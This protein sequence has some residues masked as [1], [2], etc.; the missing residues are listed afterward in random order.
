MNLKHII[1][2]IVGMILSSIFS[3]ARCAES[4]SQSVNAILPQELS[5]SKIIVEEIEYERDEF[6]FNVRIKTN[7]EQSSNLNIIGLSPMK[8]RIHTNIA[9][10]ITV[11][12]S[13]QEFKHRENKYIFSPSNIYIT[14]SSYTI[15]NPYDNVETGEFIPTI[16]IYSNVAPGIYDGKIVFT[17]GVI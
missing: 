4:A 8:V 13:F 9:T 5:I 1:L 16:N 11:S 14:P 7:S 12:A 10:P 15:N 6:L 2:L 17:L 3:S